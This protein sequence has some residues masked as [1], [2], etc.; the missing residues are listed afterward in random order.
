MRGIG[1]HD[2]SRPVA[3][4]CWP[5]PSPATVQ[6]EPERSKATWRPFGEKTGAASPAVEVTSERV[7]FAT[8]SWW[9]PLS[10]A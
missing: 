4:R 1:C 10:S 9:M 3:T 7:P 6:I 8:S 5:V 2:G